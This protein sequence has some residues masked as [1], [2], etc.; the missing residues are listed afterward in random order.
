MKRKL[1][2]AAATL[3]LFLVFLVALL[4][5][6]VALGWFSSPGIGFSGISG[7]IWSG[8]VAQVNAG[9]IALGRLQWSDGSVAGLIGRPAWDIELDRPDGFVRGRIAIR[10]G[11]TLYLDDMDA[12]G[13]LNSLASLL[14]LYGTEG[15][16]TARID[17]LEV[18]D[19]QIVLIKGRVVLSK[20]KTNA[21]KSGDLGSIELIFPG[22][23][24]GPRTG[25]VTAMDGPLQLR[26][27][28]IRIGA[29]G[30]YEIDGRVAPTSDAPSEIVDAMQFFG[31][32]DS[33]GFRQFSQAGAL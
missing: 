14:P 32:P 3:L 31:S 11:S 33:E 27:G 30:S 7:T 2:L 12:V 6:S 19:G 24:A 1:V 15:G 18:E 22:D 13:S 10:S 4:P 25:Q 23:D 16:V 28:Q 29:D 17:R 9:G 5:A 21:L 26:D 20:I 8:S